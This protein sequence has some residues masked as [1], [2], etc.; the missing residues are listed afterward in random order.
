MIRKPVSVPLHGFALFAFLCLFYALASRYFWYHNDIG[1]HL[2][3]GELILQ[4]GKVPTTDPWSYTTQGAPWYNLAWL[5][6]I[7]AALVFR[8]AGGL[9]AL[10]LT[11]A[12]GVATLC[13][14]ASLAT[15]MGARAGVVLGLGALVGVAF[16]F[17]EPPD[18]FLCFAPQ[19]MT[20]LFIALLPCLLW[21]FEKR[22]SPLLYALITLLFVLWVNMHGGF[23]AGNAL[24]GCM[25]LAAAYGRNLRLLKQLTLLLGMTTAAALLNPYGLGIMDGILVTLAHPH[26]TSISE[27]QPFF[28]NFKPAF[29]TPGL[30]YTA[31]FLV[32]LAGYRR[33]WRA[34]ALHSALLLISLILLVKSYSVLRYFSLFCVISLP[35][36]ALGLSVLW[37]GARGDETPLPASKA[38][39]AAALVIALS[40]AVVAQRN[41]NPNAMSPE[42]SP[43]AEIEFI[44]AHYPTARMANHWNFGSFIIYE[45]QGRLQPMIDGRAGTAYPDEIYAD[46]AQLYATRD[47]SALIE[48]YNITLVLW[49]HFDQ[50]MLEWFSRQ[51]QWK[52]VFT[53]HLGVVLAR[54]P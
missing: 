35:V 15:Q 16:P 20:L 43:K 26:Q 12:V 21:H 42:R 41:P 10:V 44:L 46:V 31:L 53:G 33:C 14:L 39:P 29:A 5:W 17:Y 19:Q 40:V 6:D 2:A 4:N 47:W 22:S 7:I 1:W 3:T 34:S 51:P 50:P 28:E 23:I 11:L 54:E 38:L 24:L 32:S 48:K 8:A 45:S 27:W 52:A 36:T 13:L 30:F 9:G 49:P 18:I 37:R 25:W